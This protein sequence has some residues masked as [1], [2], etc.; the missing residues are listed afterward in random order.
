MK[1]KVK[2][3]MKQP[4]AQGVAQYTFTQERPCYTQ[5]FVN[6]IPPQGLPASGN[7]NARYIC[8]PPRP[9][10]DP[11]HTYYATMF[12]EGLGLP[13]YTGY[14]LTEST[15]AFQEVPTGI[16]NIWCETPGNLF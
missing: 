16:D 15:V 12:D 13:I 1:P 4:K 5:F 6:G 10:Q 2:E 7:R 3:Q 14:K 9:N 11:L 8:Q